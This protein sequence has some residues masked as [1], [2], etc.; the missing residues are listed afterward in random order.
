MFIGAEITPLAR[1]QIAEYHLPMRMRFSPT[2]RSSDQLA[3]AADLALL[4]SWST[5]RN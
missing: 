2:T 3:H 1:R 4:P 5:N